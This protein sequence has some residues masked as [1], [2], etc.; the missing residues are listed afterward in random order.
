MRMSV[1]LSRELPIHRQLVIDLCCWLQ[2]RN[3]E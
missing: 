1:S 2:L 3:C